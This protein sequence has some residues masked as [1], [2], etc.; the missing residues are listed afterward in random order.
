MV[1]SLLEDWTLVDPNSK[2]HAHILET[3]AQH[4]AVST[5]DGAPTSEGIRVLQIALET[6]AVGDLVLEAVE[7]VVTSRQIETLTG[8][9]EE[10]PL[11]NRAASEIWKMLLS[12]SLARRIFGDPD[13]ELEVARRL[14]ARADESLVEILLDRLLLFQRAEVGREVIE[15]V[16]ALG[17][18]SSLALLKRIEVA[19]GEQRQQLL[20]L[21]QTVAVLPPGFDA[22]AYA[23]APEPMVRLEALRLMMRNPED[24]DEAIHTAL[25][26]DDERVVDL[27]LETGMTE[28]PRQS[29]SRLMLLLNSPKRSV[30]L[31]ARAIPVLAQFDAPSIREWLIGNLVLR[32]G[33]FRRRKLAPK[34]PILCAKLRLL[35][36]RW[37]DHPE[38]IRALDLARRSGD[39]ELMAAA[40]AEGPNP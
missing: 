23:T 13:L 12:P 34:T 3:L 5:S 39:A 29:L 24:R 37:S 17:P 15:R 38:V 19:P 4:E 33:W 1:K 35:A 30:A 18:V 6:E 26:D 10:T 14:L 25:A 28:M 8:F 36:V 20:R 31:K 22:R 32:R 16:F 9:L 11:P 40:R 27:G 2:T 21:L 7:M